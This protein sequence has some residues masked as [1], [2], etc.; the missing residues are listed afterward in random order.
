MVSSL[1]SR[2][3]CRP[4]PPPPPPLPPF[5]SPHPLPLHPLP[6]S[7]LLFFFILLSPT[8][9]L[10]S[11]F[12]P[13]NLMPIPLFHDRRL[14]GASAKRRAPMHA[15]LLPPS[16]PSLPIAT[17]ASPPRPASLPTRWN[18]ARSFPSREEERGRG[19]RRVGKR[20]DEDLWCYPLRPGLAMMTQ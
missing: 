16:L 14:L 3:P 12:P 19:E 11:S 7:P 18:L 1:S 15:P 9:T 20:R 13:P 4:H 6:H 17:A 2:L 10:D 5:Q 8:Y